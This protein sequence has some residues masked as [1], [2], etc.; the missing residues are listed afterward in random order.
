MRQVDAFVYYDDVQYDRDGWRNRDCVRTLEGWQW[1]TV[2]VRLKQRFGSLCS[3][4]ETDNRNAWARKHRMTIEQSYARAPHTRDA[5]APLLSFH[6]ADIDDVAAA[7]RR[8][9]AFYPEQVAR[10]GGGVRAS[11]AFQGF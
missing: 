5:L 3:E 1:L 8:I 10:I 9:T 4:V 11:A 6:P 2:P 7:L